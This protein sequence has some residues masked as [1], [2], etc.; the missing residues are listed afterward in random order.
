MWSKHANIII[1]EGNA[2]A[3]DVRRLAR[4]LRSKIKQQFD[5]ELEEEVVYIN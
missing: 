4:K 2:K 3:A 5:I 1:N